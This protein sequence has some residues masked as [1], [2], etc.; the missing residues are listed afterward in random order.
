MEHVF[1]VFTEKNASYQM[2]SFK[3][4]CQDRQKKNYRKTTKKK[5]SIEKEDFCR[6]NEIKITK[7]HYGTF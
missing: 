5:K 3:S 4:T 7:F 1:A 6:S 2:T